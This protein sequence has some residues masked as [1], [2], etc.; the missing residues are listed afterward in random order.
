MSAPIKFIA[1]FLNVAFATHLFSTLRSELDWERRDTAPR[2]EYW[3]NTTGQSYT[4]GHGLGKRTYEAKS[5]PFQIHNVAMELDLHTE[6]NPIEYGCFLN[7]YEDGTDA[8]GWHSD[9]DPAI[10][11]D[12]PIAVITL[13][14]TRRIEFCEIGAKG[15]APGI[16]LTNGSLFMMGAGMQ[17]THMHR[18]PK[19]TPGLHL[20][21]RISLTYR[22]LK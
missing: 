13:G 21:P 19:V 12:Y 8:L 9:D 16:D 18:I 15:H 20:P 1:P 3:C 10:D 5:M 22:A 6:F 7:M 4:Y 17:Q 11:H 14:E 2:A